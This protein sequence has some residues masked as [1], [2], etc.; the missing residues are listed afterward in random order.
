MNAIV[1]LGEVV[2][3]VEQATLRHLPGCGATAAGAQ[4]CSSAVSDGVTGVDDH[5]HRVAAASSLPLGEHG[6]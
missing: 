1:S 5:R 4:M 6:A 2:G 3:R